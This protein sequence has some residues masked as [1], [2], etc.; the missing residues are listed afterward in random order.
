MRQAAERNEGLILDDLLLKQ[1]P[2]KQPFT[3]CLKRPERPRGN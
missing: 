3:L 2:Q 1:S